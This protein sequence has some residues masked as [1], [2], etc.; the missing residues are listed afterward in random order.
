MK[1]RAANKIKNAANKIFVVCYENWYW[2]GGILM[3]N[4]IKWNQSIVRS[5]MY[6][7]TYLRTFIQINGKW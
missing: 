7:I 4:G 3:V 5:I 2:I 1:R 6:L